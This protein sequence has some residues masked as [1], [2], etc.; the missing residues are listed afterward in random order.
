MSN[1]ITF[2]IL[3]TLK[4]M[5]INFYVNVAVHSALCSSNESCVCEA[6][7]SNIIPYEACTLLHGD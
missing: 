4:L 6:N 5:L 2:P 7:N 3:I 1:C